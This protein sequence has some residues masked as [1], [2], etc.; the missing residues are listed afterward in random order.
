MSG[1]NSN[2]TIAHPGPDWNLQWNYGWQN[3]QLDIVGFLAVLGEGSVLANAQVSSLSRLFLLPRLLPAPQALLRPNRPVTLPS[4]TA[5]V[6]AVYSG[7]VK[8]HVHHVA[9]VLLE[10]DEMPT[11]MVRCVEVKKRNDDRKPT[12]MDTFFR[13]KSGRQ[14]TQSP[15]LGP[16]LIKARAN[17]PL[18]WV[19]LSGFFLSVLLLITSFLLGDGW[20]VVATLLLSS[21]STLIGIGNKWSLRLPQRQRGNDPP[22]GDVVIRYPNGSYLIV[23]CDEDVAREL[24]FAPEEIEYTINDALYRVI[25]LFGTLMLMVGVIALANSKLELQFA[26]AASY[27]ISNAAHWAVAALPARYHWDFS[28]YEITEQ[29]IV[30]GPK[31]KTFTEALWKAIVLTKSTRWVRNGKAAPQT[32]V[33]DDWLKE[34]ED[35]ARDALSHT[36]PLI[37]PKW[38]GQNPKKGVIWDVPANWHAKQAWD[39][40]NETSTE[41]KGTG[42]LP[43]PVA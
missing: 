42:R 17:G 23:R 2:T 11:F 18:S 29:S 4:A 37:D 14:N 3:F 34:A 38:P 6:T 43:R 12:R 28:C 32:Q 31:N 41:F 33:W 5:S 7:N 9:N 40:L 21:L 20:S 8:D 19:T 36:G 25:A 15:T 39:Q 1:G 26:W 35:Q 10:G 27:V 13:G 30:G 24:Y 22:D 16:P